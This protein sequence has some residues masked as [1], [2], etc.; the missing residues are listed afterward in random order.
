[1]TRRYIYLHDNEEQYFDNIINTTDADTTTLL[2]ESEYKTHASDDTVYYFISCY[3]RNFEAFKMEAISPLMHLR[4]DIEDLYNSDMTATEELINELSDRPTIS[5]P[6][7]TDINNGNVKVLVFHALE[8]YHSVNMNYIAQLLNVDHKQ[9]IF[10]TGDARYYNPTTNSDGSTTM[11]INYW[12]RNC[13]HIPLKSNRLLDTQLEKYSTDTTPRNYYNTFYN[14]RIRDHRINLMSVLLSKGL[15]SDMIWSWGGRVD[16]SDND[17]KLFRSI[18]YI[19]H[20][21]VR[22]IGEQY[23]AA[24]LDVLSWDNIQNGLPAKEDLQVNLVDTIN[25]DHLYDTYYQLICETWASSNTTFLSEKSFKPFALGQIFLSWS[26]QGTVTMLRKLGYD[27]FD[28]VIDHSY[29]N[30]LDDKD[31]IHALT[32]EISRI[33]NTDKS[34][35]HKMTQAPEYQ[36]RMIINN[37]HLLNSYGRNGIDFYYLENRI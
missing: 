20:C 29:D 12:E 30:I 25:E 22:L 37:N 4:E 18:G 2:P 7:L 11:W 21:F 35:L 34:V 16:Q 33:N 31:R 6:M 3:D 23:E 26:D 13:A 28:D 9:L 17:S 32:K 24:V 14:R 36:A 5:E 19:R 27:V 10:I 1:M 15:L 8:G